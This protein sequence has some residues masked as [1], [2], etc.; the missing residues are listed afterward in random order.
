MR[1]ISG[2]FKG[3][4]INFI[5]NLNTRPLK[6]LVRENI[7][8][9]LK[10]SKD[11]NINVEKA[12][13]LDLYSGVGSFGIECLSRGANKVT[14]VEHDRKAVSILKDN[15]TNLSITNKADVYNIKVEQIFEKRLKEKY[16]IFFF[17]PPFKD[18]KFSQYLD[19]IK[20]EKIFKKKH[21]IIIHR[22]KKTNDDLNSKIK[23]VKEKIY[24]RSKIIFGVFS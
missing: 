21:I 14:F 15:L 8:N 3:K 7:F 12:L 24:G 1:I 10:H 6:D 19:Y 18:E 13:I 5:K 17:D 16:H 22:E 23:I 20:K 2:K 4:S 11:I 9:I